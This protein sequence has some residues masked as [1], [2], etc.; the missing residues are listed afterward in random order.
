MHTFFRFLAFAALLWF[1]AP[2]LSHVGAGDDDVE[3]E[4]VL[5]LDLL[6]KLHAAGTE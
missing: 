2:V 1:A 6:D 5:A 3:I 4:P